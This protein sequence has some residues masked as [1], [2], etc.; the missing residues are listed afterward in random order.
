MQGL[1]ALKPWYSR[2]LGRIVRFAVDRNISPDVFT[3]VGIVG[4]V[5][6]AVCVALGCWLPALLMLGVRL[7][8]AN[9]DGAVA[10]AREV[11]RPWGFVLNEIGDRS[12]DLIVFGGLFVLAARTAGVTSGAA[13]LTCV[14]AAAAT[15]P[16]TASLAAAGAGAT[17]RNGGPFG[18]T[19]RCL[20]VVVATALPGLLVW[21]C[22]IVIA[23]SLLTAALRLRAA[24]RELRGTAA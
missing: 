19:E 14:A 7:G 8:G 10:R 17:R 13:I 2:R 12:S 5:L 24:H 1:Y 4:A 18:K 15:L 21:I 11:S 9:L 23:G 3:L 16:T 20:A 22:A 6:A